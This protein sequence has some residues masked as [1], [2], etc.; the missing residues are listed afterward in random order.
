[1]LFRSS[2]QE[3]ERRLNCRGTDC[4]E[5]IRLR[6]ANAKAEMAE[7]ELYDFVVMNDDL[8]T[9]ARMLEAI[10]LAMRAKKRRHISGKPLCLP[11]G[12]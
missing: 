11:A 5:T 3:Q 4:A 1:M 7:V 10:I 6:L 8:D 12:H 2:W 9:A